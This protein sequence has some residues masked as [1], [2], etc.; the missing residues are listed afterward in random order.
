MASR[1]VCM[2][3]LCVALG[4]RN[5]SPVTLAV[6]D[7]RG[8]T[9]ETTDGVR[10][11]SLGKTSAIAVS[12]RRDGTLLIVKPDGHTLE[13]Q[14][15]GQYSD[16]PDMPGALAAAW[17]NAGELCAIVRKRT[18]DGAVVLSVCD[19]KGAS[20]NEY[21]LPL[22]TSPA[23]FPSKPAFAISWSG[24]DQRICVSTS[25]RTQRSRAAECAVVNR[26][27]GQ[28]SCQSGL[29]DVYFLGDAW[30][31][32]CVESS[33]GKVRLCKVNQQG[34]DVCFDP[35]ELRNGSYVACSDS[36]RELYVVWL[37]VGSYIPAFGRLEVRSRTGAALGVTQSQYP[38]LSPV[39]VGP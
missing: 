29:S 3:T 13:Y 7:D 8:V 34:N 33:H 30:A 2:V 16:G 6:G 22:E 37:P 12:Y 9:V 10:R 17:S 35:M 23:S 38:I 24:T 32:G 39:C 19:A 21:V 31:V 36:V 27:T 25:N 5:S 4:C 26:Q 14:P 15:S 28:V 1:I 18:Q 11:F 20:L